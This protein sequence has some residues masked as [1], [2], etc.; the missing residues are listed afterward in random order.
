MSS[1]DLGYWAI[2]RQPPMTYQDFLR[3]FEETI[4][5]ATTRLQEISTDE[6]NKSSEGEWSPKQISKR[7]TVTRQQRWNI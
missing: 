2:I 3:D 5:S 4:R 6:S 1:K 7:S